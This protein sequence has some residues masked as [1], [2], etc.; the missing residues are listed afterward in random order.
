MQITFWVMAPVTMS[1][2][3]FKKPTLR[4]LHKENIWV[5][6][7]KTSTTELD[8]NLLGWFCEA[9]YPHSCHHAKLEADINASLDAHFHE[10]KSVLLPFA[11]TFP[12]LYGW[13]GSEAP[14][15]S[16]ET[17]KP[18]RPVLSAYKHQRNSA[19]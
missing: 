15:V 16:V 9:H 6:N 17:V 11:N 4:L 5:D 3:I 14:K 12:T 1:F 19:P 10:N 7:H 2:C 8:T 18:K 13:E